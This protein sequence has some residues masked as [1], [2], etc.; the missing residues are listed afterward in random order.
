MFWNRWDILH[1]LKRFETLL[2]VLILFETWLTILWNSLIPCLISLDMFVTCLKRARNV[3]NHI[4]V[5]YRR[6]VFLKGIEIRLKHLFRHVC[7]HARRH[8]NVYTH[9]SVY[10]SAHIAEMLGPAS[11]AARNAE[12]RDWN[13]QRALAMCCAPFRGE[14]STERRVFFVFRFSHFAY[15][16]D[17]S[18]N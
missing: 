6:L 3:L 16:L 11:S 2:I 5:V 4:L 18:V 13:L 15:L 8:A 10:V 12:C 7:G 14:L 17:C 1:C 9:K